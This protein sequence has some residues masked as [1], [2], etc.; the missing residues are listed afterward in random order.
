MAGA[1]D[2]AL[3]EEQVRAMLGAE[4]PEPPGGARGRGH[5]DLRSGLVDLRDAAGDQVVTDRCFVGGREHVVDLAVGRRRDPA[6]DFAGVVVARL[7]AFEVQDREAAE[8]GQPAGERR[9]RRRRP[10]PPRGSGSRARCRRT[11][12]RAPRRRARSC[13]SRG[14][15]RRPR[16]RTWAGDRRPSS[17]RR[18]GWRRSWRSGRA[19]TASWRRWRRF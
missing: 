13:P 4:R 14:P 7:D 9:D 11:P 1:G 17:G 8:G 10:S 3:D 16:T 15:A 18:A 12:G 2:L 19:R 5:R 6:E